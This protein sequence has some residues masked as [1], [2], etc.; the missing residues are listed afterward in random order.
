MKNSFS[1]KMFLFVALALSV[2]SCTIPN[3]NA[4]FNRGQ[5][6]SLLR[7]Q[8]E[9]ISVPLNSSNAENLAELLSQEAKPTSAKLKCSG[10]LRACDRAENLLTGK[11]IPVERAPSDDDSQSSVVLSYERVA[12]YSCENRFVS[13]QTNVYNLN[14]YA[15][16]CSISSNI[17]KMVGGDYQQILKPTSAAPTS[18]DVPVRAFYRAER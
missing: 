9:T 16:G 10:S 17:V 12:A 2:A 11:N 7:V 1:L 18:G 3:E 13:N 5:P 6:E 8:S 14:H 4:Y 15:F